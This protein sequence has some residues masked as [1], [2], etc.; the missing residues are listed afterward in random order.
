MIDIRDQLKVL[1]FG[2]ISQK[3][4]LVEFS[5]PI[6]FLP[7]SFI[8]KSIFGFVDLGKLVRARE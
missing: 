4:I 5:I 8:H 2:N 7:K 3:L 6:F 1:Q